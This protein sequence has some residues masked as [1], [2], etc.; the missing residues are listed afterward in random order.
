MTSD[1]TARQQDVLAF[2]IAHQQRHHMAPTV[3]EIAS[4]IGVSS[5]AGIHRIMT[6]LKTKGYLL[7]DA[8]KKRSWR[9]SRE[10]PGK[11]VPLLGTI[12][13]GLPLESIE[14]FEGELLV[15]LT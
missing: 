12:A 2:I 13:A 4:H 10:L 14:N 15:S 6:I 3:R 8:G 5:P 11:G 7:S 1:L 9:F